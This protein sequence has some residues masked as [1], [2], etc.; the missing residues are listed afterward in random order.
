MQSDTT[1][2]L[3][4]QDGLRLNRLKGRPDNQPLIETVTSFSV[5]R[6][7]LRVPVW[8]RSMI[9]RFKHTTV[10]YPQGRAIRVLYGEHARPLEALQWAYSSSANPTGGAFDES[11][12]RAQAD[13]Y[14]LRPEGFSPQAASAI[15]RL[16]RGGRLKK[17]R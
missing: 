6:S 17:L 14:L 13:L 12:A 2:G 15:V 5:L 7:R 4:S 9:R 3:I 10:A 8:A 1:V 11:W 16:G